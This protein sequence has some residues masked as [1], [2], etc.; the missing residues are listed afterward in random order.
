MARILDRFR[1]ELGE[2]NLTYLSSVQV[3]DDD[4]VV[5]SNQ[6]F[7]KTIAN[8]EENPRAFAR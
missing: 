6:F 3:L 2:P 5:L 4:H 7:G 1:R 8:V